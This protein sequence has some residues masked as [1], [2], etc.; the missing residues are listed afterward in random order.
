MKAKY[1]LKKVKDKKTELNK[2][3]SK[4]VAMLSDDKKT[5]LELGSIEELIK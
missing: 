3:E 1:E 2:L 4:L 5:E